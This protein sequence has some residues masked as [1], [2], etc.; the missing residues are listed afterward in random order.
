MA[1]T[2][3]NLIPSMYKALDVVSRELTGMI[4]AVSLDADVAQA[5]VGQT[6]LSHVAPASTA[7]DI[8]PS[9]NAPDTGD[10]T[11][12]NLSLTIQKSRAVYF[13]WNGEEEKGLNN[14]G[15]GALRPQTLVA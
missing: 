11:I 5:A 7:V 12:G 13:R 6:V 10:Q 4:P 9:V 14:G 15:A 3:T 8:T 1:N 2:L